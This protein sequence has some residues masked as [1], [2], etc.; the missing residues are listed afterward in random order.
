MELGLWNS[1]RHTRAEASKLPEE[2]G[3]AGPQAGFLVCWSF[4]CV[5]IWVLFLVVM[6]SFT[7][8]VFAFCG[9]FVGFGG[10]L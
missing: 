6:V 3:G 2:E 1:Q 9:F 8:V 5:V 10:T 7:E 4:C